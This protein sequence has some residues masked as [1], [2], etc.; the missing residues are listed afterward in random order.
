MAVAFFGDGA[1]EEGHVHESMNLAALY[2]LP[3][4]FVCENNLYASHCT[5]ASA[6]WRDNLDR[7][8]EFHS[9]S[10]RTVDGN[11]V[12]AVYR[13]RAARRS[14]GRG[15]AR[16]RRFSNAGRFAGA[17]MWARASI[18]MSACSGAGN[19]PSGWRAIRSRRLE[20]N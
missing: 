19:W 5:G 16:D 6:A 12:E 15:R 8:G 2:R 4:I 11:D 1:L 13:R 18:W 10:R 9:D 3:V 17:G 20:E 7:A 14:S